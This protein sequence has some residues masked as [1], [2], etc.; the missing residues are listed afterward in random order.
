MKVYACECMHACECRIRMTMNNFT[1]VQ[2][3]RKPQTSDERT[4]NVDRITYLQRKHGSRPQ[5]LIANEIVDI[6]YTSS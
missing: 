3:R 5:L 1:E 2:C 6:I 4:C